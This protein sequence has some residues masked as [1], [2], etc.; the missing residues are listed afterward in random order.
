M[1]TVQAVLPTMRAKGGG[2]IV[3]I[4]TTAMFDFNK[5]HTP[6]IAAKGAHLALTRGLATDLGADNIRVNMVSPGKIWT[7]RKS[8]QPDDFVPVARTRTPLGRNANA[9]D[10]AGA[11][12]FFASDLSRFITGVNLP[13]CGG[14]IMEGG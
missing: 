11:V 7:D 14:F 3:N 8:P 6:Y 10:V 4:G 9:D 5:N 12:V 13:V 1:N 2:S